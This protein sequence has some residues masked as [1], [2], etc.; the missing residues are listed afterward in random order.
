MNPMM[1]YVA[2]PITHN[3]IGGLIDACD[4]GMTLVEMG[5]VPY[6]PQTLML[7]VLR[8]GTTDLEVGSPLYEMWLKFDFLVIDRCD[9]LFRLPGL[10][11]GADREVE[12]AKGQGKLIFDSV[13]DVL[14]YSGVV[15]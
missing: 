1:I 3:F 13:A 9:A 12:Y 6:L 4:I 14:S 15:R 11:I 8:H 2:G 10:S 7:M 5:H